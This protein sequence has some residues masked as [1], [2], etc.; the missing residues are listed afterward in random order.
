MILSFRLSISFLPFLHHLFEIQTE[1]FLWRKNRSVVHMTEPFIKKI[2][3]S[4]VCYF[5]GASVFETLLRSWE[6]EPI[7]LS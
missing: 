6:D 3:G 1:S 5:F 4:Y 2:K 7:L